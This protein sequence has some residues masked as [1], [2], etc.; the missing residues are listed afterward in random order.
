MNYKKRGDPSWKFMT[1]VIL[2]CNPFVL[3]TLWLLHRSLRVL[4]VYTTTSAASYWTQEGFASGSRTAP[5]VMSAKTYLYH[6]TSPNK[7]S[8]ACCHPSLPHIKIQ[9]TAPERTGTAEP[10]GLIVILHP[11]ESHVLTWTN[12]MRST[13]LGGS[14]ICPS[15]RLNHKRC[16]GG[17]SFMTWQ[18]K[19]HSTWEK[20]S[21]Q[22]FKNLD[23]PQ[24]HGYLMT[25][26]GG[27]LFGDGNTF[28]S[29]LEGWGRWFSCGAAMCKLLELCWSFPASGCTR[30][31]VLV[32]NALFMQH[33]KPCSLAAR[34]KVC[35][36]LQGPN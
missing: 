29:S 35:S 20:I 34:K 36:K 16:L 5:S 3:R 8:L 17:W 25:Y 6:L 9:G 12:F 13:T 1:S 11:E 33:V 22:T 2:F 4:S 18:P 26:P 32:R 10:S 30:Y 27:K 7:H 31:H 19:S 15:A 24:A 14:R 21:A 28:C 23:A